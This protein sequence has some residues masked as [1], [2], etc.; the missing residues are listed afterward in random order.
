VDSSTGALK[1][2]VSF[3]AEITDEMTFKIIAQDRGKPSLFG[4][5]NVLVQIVDVNDERPTF[6]QLLYAFRVTENEPV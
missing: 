6:S 5:A 1:A 3:D 4:V 2:I